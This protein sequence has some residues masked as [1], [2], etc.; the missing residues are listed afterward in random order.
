MDLLAPLESFL[1]QRITDLAKYH[2]KPE[3]LIREL[4][5][6]RNVARGLDKQRDLLLTALADG[7]T[8][9]P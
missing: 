8:F 3:E 5:M 6:V 1:T 4:E 2:P 9:A 7:Q